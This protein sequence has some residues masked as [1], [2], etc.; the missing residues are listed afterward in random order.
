MM[1]NRESLPGRKRVAKEGELSKRTA[2]ITGGGAGIGRSICLAMARS[3]ARIAVLDLDRAAAELVA[4]EVRVLGTEAIAVS[5]SVADP[6]GVRDAVA[7][8]RDAL[9]NIDILVNNA[10][11]SGNSPTLDL[12]VAQWNR[13][14]GVN[15]NGVFLMSQEVGRLMTAARSGSIVNMGSIYSTVAAPNRLAYCATKAAVAMMTKSLAIEWAAFGIRVN[16]VAP[17]YVRT[18]LVEE[19]VNAG[20]IDVAAIERRTPLGAMATPDD[21]AEA[22]VFLCSDRASQITGQILGVDGGWTAYGYI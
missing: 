20:K 13:V 6:T 8:V 3:G 10:G 21:I 18:H 12:D 16:A 22:V 5:A 19:L 14:V 9:G 4:A 1:I 17:G 7:T 11:I 2:L 15:L